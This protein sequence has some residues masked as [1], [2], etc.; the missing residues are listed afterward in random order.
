MPNKKPLSFFN[1]LA[2]VFGV[3]P[4]ASNFESVRDSAARSRITHTQPSDFRKEMTSFDRVELNRIVRS[5]EKSSSVVRAYISEIATYA[6]GDGI[7][8]EVNSEDQDWNE[9]AD[10]IIEEASM[11]P[12]LCGRFNLV[13]TE[14]LIC[15]A[16]DCDGDIF[17]LFVRDEQ[18][19]RPKIQLIESHRIGNANGTDVAGMTDGIRFDR[20]GRPLVY[21]VIQDDGSFRDFPASVVAHI[22]EPEHFSGARGVSPLQT[23]IPTLRDLKEILAAEKLAVKDNSRIARV[24]YSQQGEFAEGDVGILGTAP[25]STGTD[26]NEI[27]NRAGGVSIALSPG[28]RLETFTNTRPSASFSGFVDHLTRDSLV[29]TGLPSDWIVDPNKM[30]GAVVRLVTARVERRIRLRQSAIEARFLRRWVSFII[31]SAIEDGRLEPIKGWERA[32][33]FIFPRKISVDAGRESKANRDDIEFGLK[34]IADDFAERG[35]RY[36]KELRGRAN[37]FILAKKESERT[38]LPIEFFFKPSFSWLYKSMNSGASASAPVQ[39]DG[40]DEPDPANSDLPEQDSDERP[41]SEPDDNEVEDEVASALDSVIAAQAAAPDSQRVTVPAFIRS[42]ARRGL[43]LYEQGRGGA[44]LKRQTINE[45]RDLASGATNVEKVR[46]MSAWLAR[47]AVDLKAPKNSNPKDPEFPGAGLVAWLL[48]GG[49]ADG[50]P[51]AEEWARRTLERVDREG[52][53]E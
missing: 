16:I 39:S 18:T 6:V 5:L 11:F 20:F 34:R 21:R 26:P 33:E 50:S 22:Y 23:A 8:W 15:R 42:N 12:T 9:K 44:G 19:G 45:A 49:D 2:S 30:G 29:G 40:S 37:D 43:R 24:L 35:L 13:E 4:K 46:R 14:H 27:D 25:G 28:E 41:D 48:W 36:R 38:G 3:S 10:A 1:R 31:A 47:H 52:N 17:S 7:L 51:R 53:R 32:V